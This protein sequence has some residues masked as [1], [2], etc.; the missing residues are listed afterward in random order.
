M[1][2]HF[3]GSSPYL[4]RTKVCHCPQ[5][6]QDANSLFSGP[7]GAL[8]SLPTCSLVGSLGA[9]P[10]EAVHCGAQLALLGLVLSGAVEWFVIAVIHMW[11][12]A[13]T[14][15]IFEFRGISSPT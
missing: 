6:P 9:S 14:S 13:S 12:T 5:V 4:G 11:A 7:A 8:L 2:G 3:R 1:P 10:P 15:R